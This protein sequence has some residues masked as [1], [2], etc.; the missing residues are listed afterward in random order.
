MSNL[1]KVGS[2]KIIEIE[3]SD[4][5]IDYLQ[6]N[7]SGESTNVQI[8]REYTLSSDGR[9][10]DLWRQYNRNSLD[11]V[12]GKH[13]R[14][15]Y[16]ITRNLL[17]EIIEVHP[18]TVIYEASQKTFIDQGETFLLSGVSDMVDYSYMSRSLQKLEI[19]MNYFIQQNSAIFVKYWHTNPDKN[20]SDKFLREYSLHNVVDSKMLKVVLRDN[21]IPE[22]KHEFSQWGIE[23]EKLE[24]FFEKTYFEEIFGV[25]EEP[26]RMDYLYF[27][28]INRMY[29]IQDVYLN[30]GIGEN[31][32]FYTCVIKKYEDM[33]NVEK[34]DDDLDFL[35]N[36]KIDDYDD[37]QMDEMEDISNPRQNLD[38]VGIDSLTYDEYRSDLVD[39]KRCEFDNN[40][41][42]I[43][44]FVYDMSISGKN[45]V[46]VKYLQ[47][48]T[49]KDGL[50][51]M[52]W[53]EF[54]DEKPQEIWRMENKN[55]KPFSIWM[56]T[57]SIS[58][59]GD[60]KLQTAIDLR[61]KKFYCV[62]IGINNQN[63]FVRMNIYETSTQKS[64]VLV[65]TFERIINIDDFSR[66]IYGERSNT[67]DIDGKLL[68]ISGNYAI[69]QIRIC[70]HDIDKVHH[71]YIMSYSSVK[72]PSRFFIIDDCHA[73]LNMDKKS[74]SL[75]KE[76]NEKLLER[77]QM[78]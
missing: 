27:S 4:R 30:H 77:R 61:I 70:K 48:V 25:G 36:M 7:I 76:L 19:D 2:S 75:F 17:D 28:E 44:K 73:P 42:S 34:R 54:L 6:E 29:Y 35:K 56:S 13:I 66:S 43:G 39:M 26:R 47:E 68:L 14:L 38:N 10:W 32:N 12:H 40:G 24:V 5:K 78:K 33:S 46:A 58:V 60:R 20:S 45:D 57:K 74:M 16:T 21:Q 71:S 22:P 31:G 72:N 1:Q 51:F 59:V 53:V 8:L 15:K 67:I 64:T 50:S 11:G 23:F 18:P 55:G 52:F 9:N 3:K 37:E 49:S 63:G 65:D 69:R 62:V 41:N